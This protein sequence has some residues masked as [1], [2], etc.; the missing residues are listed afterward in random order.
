MS[1]GLWAEKLPATQRDSVLA[2][3][4]PKRAADAPG[5]GGTGAGGFLQSAHFLQWGFKY[6]G[7]LN[8]LDY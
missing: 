8:T 5:N 3:L 2:A 7:L 1:L 6:I 4:T